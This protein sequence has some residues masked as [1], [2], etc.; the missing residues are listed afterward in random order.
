LKNFGPACFVESYGFS[1]R[2]LQNFIGR[3]V[4]STNELIDVIRAEAD[5]AIVLATQLYF[6]KHFL[7]ADRSALFVDVDPRL[8]SW[9]APAQPQPTLRAP[10]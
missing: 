5:F 10:A 1:H 4:D 9:A 2:L 3:L 6:C 8:V 7:A